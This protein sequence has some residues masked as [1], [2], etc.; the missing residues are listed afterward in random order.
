M[1]KINQQI[2]ELKYT[3][4]CSKLDAEKIT[5]EIELKEMEIKNIQQEHHESLKALEQHQILLQ[6]KEKEVQMKELKIKN[7]EQDHQQ[8]VK[9]LEYKDQIILEKSDEVELH[10]STMIRIKENNISNLGVIQQQKQIIQE[11]TF[12]VERLAAHQEESYRL[13][14]KLEDTYKLIEENERVYFSNYN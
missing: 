2:E 3:A 4:V 11:K 6:D 8:I 7:I 5:S 10:K 1:D 13:K 12:E 9:K 14:N